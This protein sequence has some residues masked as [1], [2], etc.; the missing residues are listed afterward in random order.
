MFGSA[1]TGRKAKSTD[2]PDSTHTQSKEQ[3]ELH[4]HHPG[5]EQKNTIFSYLRTQYLLFLEGM[6]TSNKVQWLKMHF[7]PNIKETGLKT[8]QHEFE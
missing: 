7:G 8:E 2:A 1:E 4:Q 5:L 6:S 3:F